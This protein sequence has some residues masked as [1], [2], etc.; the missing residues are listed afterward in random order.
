VATESPVGWSG[1]RWALKRDVPLVTSFHTDF[2][3]YVGGYGLGLLERPVWTYLRSFHDDAMMTFCPS[4]ATSTRLWNHGFHER[5][6]I[7]S[8]GI[9]AETFS[10]THRREDVRR[11][12]A[13]GAERILLYVGRRARTGSGSW[14]A[15]SGAGKKLRRAILRCYNPVHDP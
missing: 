11:N 4:T 6:R 12:L 2:A 1:R 13:P 14:M 7:W 15:C 9:D 5:I 10:P 8:R 3:A